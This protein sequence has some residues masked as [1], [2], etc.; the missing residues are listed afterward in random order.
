M[1]TWFVLPA[2]PTSLLT[3]L[4]ADHLRANIYPEVNYPEFGAFDKL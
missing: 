4:D 1:V 2:S 3:W